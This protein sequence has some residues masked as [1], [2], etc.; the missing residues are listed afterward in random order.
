MRYLGQSSEY[1]PIGAKFRA[2]LGQ[3][4]NKPVRI[5]LV[6]AMRDEGPHLLEWVAHHRAIGVTDFLIYTNAC[7]DGTEALARALA[8][9]GVHQIDNAPPQ[10]KS[11]QWNALH[12]AWD[13]P[14]R[15]SADWLLCLD[16]DEFINLRAPLV[17]LPDLISAL[18]PRVD[19]IA[20]PWRLFGHNGQLRM[21]DALTTETFTRA[22]PENCAYPVTASQFKTLFRRHGPFRQIG[23][24]RPRLKKEAQAVWV[25]GSGQRL[26][27]VFGR[28]EHR[29]NLYG[30]P[31]GTDLVQVN[32]YSLRSAEA[33]LLKMQRGLPN[34]QSKPLDLTYWVERNFNTVEDTSIARMRPG[35][36]AELARLRALPGVVELHEA[37]VAQHRARLDTLLREAKMVR[38][39]GR[40]MLAADS[41]VPP[42]DVVQELVQMYGAADDG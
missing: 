12:S 19:A 41:Q 14:K 3:G 26:P 23:V 34:R 32:H 6:T 10:G 22:A 17:Q 2:V 7:S 25:N 37:A 8:P 38:F 24:H 28:A 15:K 27:E 9:A 36:E 39:L 21:K 31:S 11:L 33:F 40:L 13:H 30:L 20:L 42:P 16:C 1:G 35:T 4:D 18:A 5:T 29:I